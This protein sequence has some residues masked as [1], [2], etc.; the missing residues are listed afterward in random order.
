TGRVWSKRRNLWR[1][2]RPIGSSCGRWSWWL[3][4]RVRERRRTRDRGGAGMTDAIIIG[5]GWISEHYFTTVAKAQSFQARVLGRRA[6]WDAE[7]KAGR[8]TALS[9]F[10]AQ[11]AKL[12][13]DLS[14]L[15]EMLDPEA[16]AEAAAGVDELA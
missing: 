14:R 12:E 5:D 4:R 16:D 2:W 15:A 9:R 7:A 13:L 3:A 8:E 10:T 11:R 6:A 1:R